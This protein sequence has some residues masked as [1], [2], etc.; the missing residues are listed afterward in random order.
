MIPQTAAALGMVRPQAFY[1]LYNPSMNYGH[2]QTIEADAMEEYNN[3]IPAPPRLLTYV[4][5]PQ[6][7]GKKKKKLGKKR[8]LKKFKKCVPFNVRIIKKSDLNVGENDILKNVGEDLA[9]ISLNTSAY[10]TKNFQ[11]PETLHVLYPQYLFPKAPLKPHNSKVR[12]KQPHNQR[13]R[14]NEWRASLYKRNNKKEFVLQEPIPGAVGGSPP[15]GPLLNLFRNKWIPVSENYLEKPDQ[16]K[17]ESS[18]VLKAQNWSFTTTTQSPIVN[19]MKFSDPDYYRYG[20]YNLDFKEE[21]N[22][23]SSSEKIVTVTPT[24]SWAPVLQPYRMVQMTKEE[25]QT[26]NTLI[27]NFNPYKFGDKLPRNCS[28][29]DDCR[30]ENINTNNFHKMMEKHKATYRYEH[31]K[32]TTPSTLSYYMEEGSNRFNTHDNSLFGNSEYGRK[33]PLASAKTLD[34]NPELQMITAK[35]PEDNIINIFA[36]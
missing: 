34:L 27:P 17:A 35:Y 5:Q 13:I 33:V 28:L 20:V 12:I 19:T 10:S 4:Q 9:L 22:Y 1:N 16:N 15:P 6:N 21:T 18:Y 26:P 11:F 36:H 3:K 30:Y 23:P 24:T 25:N 14:D 31:P 32:T 2:Y 8:P 7:R 29:N